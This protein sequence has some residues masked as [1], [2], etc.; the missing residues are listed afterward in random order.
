MTCVA[1]RQ[2]QSGQNQC[3]CWYDP[4]R[5]LVYPASSRRLPIQ[6]A[7]TPKSFPTLLSVAS[8]LKYSLT[9]SLILSGFDWKRPC[10]RL[11]QA[12]QRIFKFSR[13]LLSRSLSI[14]CT[15]TRPFFP[16]SSHRC[17]RSH[18]SNATARAI[19]PWILWRDSSLICIS[20]GSIIIPL[21]KKAD[22]TILILGVIYG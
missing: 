15:S 11:W 22:K 21:V 3:F 6:F 4:C 5:F 16:Q 14:W 1:S 2:V 10:A 7:D 8:G 18:P 19:M 20:L 13:E 12:R 9:T 17:S